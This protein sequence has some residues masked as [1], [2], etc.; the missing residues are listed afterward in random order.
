LDIDDLVH[1]LAKS[2]CFSW[3]VVLVSTFRGLTITGGAVGV[4]KATTSSVV[5][6]IF[7]IIVI[8]SI[9]TTAATVL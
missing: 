2:L 7:L 5:A 6:S 3:T 8:D 1:G 9:F 4:G